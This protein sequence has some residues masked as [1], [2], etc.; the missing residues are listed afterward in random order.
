MIVREI[1]RR[2]DYD[3]ERINMLYNV[4]SGE[5]GDL[6]QNTKSNDDKMVL[7]LW[8]H[9]QSC[10]FLSARILDHLNLDNMGHVDPTVIWDLLES[11]PEKPFKVISVH[12]CFRV[13]PNYANDLRIQYARQLMLI[14]KSEL[15]SWLI[16]QLVKRKVTVGKLDPHMWQKVAQTNYALS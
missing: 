2:C 13:H 12:D 7:R 15:L 11:L 6:G 10:G 9:Y 3:I 1:T 4:L 16:S 8:D 5:D 14:A